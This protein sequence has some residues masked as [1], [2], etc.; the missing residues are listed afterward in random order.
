MFVLMVSMIVSTA[1]VVPMTLVTNDA[2]HGVVVMME[3]AV[4]AAA[5]DRTSRG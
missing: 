2:G 5:A 4:A 1:A 3:T